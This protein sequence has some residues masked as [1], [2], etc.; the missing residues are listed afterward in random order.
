MSE[1]GA[2]RTLAETEDFRLGGMVVSPSTGRV[3]VE[4]EP[5][6]VEALTMAVLVTLARAEGATVSRDA[7]IQ[8]CWGGRIVSDDAVGRAIAKVRALERCA[9]PAPFTLETVPKIGYRLIGAFAKIRSEAPQ[10]DI[11]APSSPP[12]K[13]LPRRIPAWLLLGGGILAVL[14]SVAAL[15]PERFAPGTRRPASF[16]DDGGFRAVTSTDFE[17]ALLVL[18]EQ[19]LAIYLH[20][21]WNPNWKLDSEGNEALHNLMMVCERHKQHDR[22]AL[23]RVARLL[24]DAG[25]DPRAR[26]KWKDTPLII[27]QSPRYCGPNHPVVA[28]LKGVV[29]ASR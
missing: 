21:G 27:A 2:G 17:D 19:R 4:G 23:V 18:D 1:T 29:A 5:T 25:A 3:L 14:A 28:Y 7:L 12:T 22:E 24:V 15:G 13:R 8:A 6:R 26:N 16:E 20:N 11:P 10:A 9:T